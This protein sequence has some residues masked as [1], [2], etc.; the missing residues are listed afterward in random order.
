VTSAVVERDLL[1]V[2]CAI[3]AGIHAALAPEHLR[4]G[5]GPGTGFL[6]ASLLL[7]ALSV[8]LTSRPQSQFVVAAAAAVLAGLLVA[9]AL[10]LT[11]GVPL[12][13]PSPEPADG[14]GLATKAIELVGLVAAVRLFS[15]GRS[16]GRLT[17]LDTKGMT[18]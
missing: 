8:A 14:L 4:E 11:T 9:Y 3:S 17:R 12:L 7:A 16:F 10:A 5:A 6:A 15:C 1:I 2:G 13:H 18:T